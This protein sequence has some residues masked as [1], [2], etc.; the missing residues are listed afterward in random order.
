[1]N[2]NRITETAEA[3]FQLYARGKQDTQ[4]YATIRSTLELT[5]FLSSLE[6]FSAT[7]AF[8]MWTVEQAESFSCG[9]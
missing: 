9:K 4:I 8:E 7:Y 1:M 2:L 5:R 3:K 6:L